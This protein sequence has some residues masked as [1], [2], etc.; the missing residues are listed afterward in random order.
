[1][2][3][4]YALG[5]CWSCGRSFTFNPVLVPSFHGEPICETCIAEVN[6]R[7]R[8]DGLPEWPVLEG[9]YEPVEE[10]QW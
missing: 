3:Y 10:G 2:G 1:M 4:Y 6:R 8:A 9:A 7:R 5:E